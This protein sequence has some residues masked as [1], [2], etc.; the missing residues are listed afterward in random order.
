[1]SS[2]PRAKDMPSSVTQIATTMAVLG[3]YGG[4]NTPAEHAPKPGAWVAMLPIGC[5]W[6]T[7]C[8]APLRLR[9]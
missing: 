7:P 4:T 6:S 1:M 2:R 9:R 3:L 8:W 5:A